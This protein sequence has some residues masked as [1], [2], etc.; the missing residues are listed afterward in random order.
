MSVSGASGEFGPLVDRARGGRP[1][2]LAA[3]YR[4][5]GAALYRLAYH[6]RARRDGSLIRYSPS[7]LMITRFLRCP[8]H[9]P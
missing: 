7:T 9:S 8:S 4:A 6:R 3:L 1:E 5:H 2:A